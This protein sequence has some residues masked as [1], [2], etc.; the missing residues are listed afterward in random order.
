VICQDYIDGVSLAKLINIQKSGH[1]P[2]TVVQRQLGSDFW[3]QMASLGHSLVH[4]SIWA[5]YLFGDPHPG[6]VKLLPDNKIGLIDFG[7]TAKAPADKS[8]YLDL[9]ECYRT[10][11]EGSF[12][13][14]GFMLNAVRFFDA[15]LAGAISSIDSY[16]HRGQSGLAAK[17]SSTSGNTFQA[18]LQH[19][20][21]LEPIRN[22]KII[23]LFVRILNSGNKYGL[24][25]DTGKLA[26]LRSARTYI[27]LLR[28]FGGNG[29][30]R[31][32]MESVLRH[33]TG[34]AKKYQHLLPESRRSPLIPYENALEIINDWL[35][36]IASADPM[37]YIQLL[38]GKTY[39]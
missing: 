28:Q 21:D 39:A 36:Q 38:K 19:G 20:M 27:G 17:I 13:A 23:P 18:H 26:L 35:C 25:L 16:R 14:G 37:L 10:L 8:A 2:V 32:I 11:Y 33:E 24:R 6:N 3:Q 1:D 30:E 12:D 31:T 22:T 4:G 15:E 9:L 34:Y 5:D 29:H 7:I